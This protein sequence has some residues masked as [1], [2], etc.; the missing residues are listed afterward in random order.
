MSY[1]NSKNRILI[2]DKHNNSLRVLLETS[3]QIGINAKVA[4]TLS[5]AAKEI[6]KSYWDIIFIADDFANIN[7]DDCNDKTVINPINYIHSLTPETNLIVISNK[8]NSE[9]TINAIKSGATN[10]LPR[11]IVKERLLEIIS[12]KKN[13]LTRKRQS[14][15]IAHNNGCYYMVGSSE[16]V[17][18][19]IQTAQKVAKTNASV[20]LIGPNGSGKELIAQLIHNSSKRAKNNFVRLNCAALNESLLQSELFGH[21]KGS[22]TGAMTTRKGKFERANHGTI[23]LDEI[24][25]TSLT[26]QSQLLRVLEQGSIERVGGDREISL[27]LRV[28][29]TTNRDIHEQIR[30]GKFREDLYYRLSAVTIKVPPLKD[31]KEDILELVLHFLDIFSKDTDR[32][33]K[34]IDKNLLEVF[35]R[36]SWPGNI[37]QLR[38]AVESCLILGDGPILSLVNTDWMDQDLLCM[39]RVMSDNNSSIVGK[40]LRELEKQAILATL[41]HSNGNQTKAAKLLGITNR[42]LRDKI[43]RYRDTATTSDNSLRVLN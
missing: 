27:D 40:S 17:K 6:K 29:A 5:D 43:K 7:E 39:H 34:K 30:L 21:E 12:S 8:D 24:T 37:R 22:F 25:E 38:N 13:K 33:I 9:A 11:P 41:E 15:E 10:F 3:A 20:M 35:E 2:L 16:K 4:T 19:L 31:R 28:I 32:E 26:F 42:T 23:L 36:Y 14:L 18:N 1:K